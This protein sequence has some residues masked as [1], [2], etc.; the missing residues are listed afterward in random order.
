MRLE[1]DFVM[2]EKVFYHWLC[3]VLCFVSTFHPFACQKA[4]V[5]LI[6]SYFKQDETLISLVENKMHII[7]K[8]QSCYWRLFSLR[9]FFTPIISYHCFLKF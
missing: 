7:G 6:S 9:H 2:P 5:L 4:K 3:F 1:E 8:H